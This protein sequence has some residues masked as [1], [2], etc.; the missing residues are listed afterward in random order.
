MADKSWIGNSAPW[1]GLAALLVVQFLL[2]YRHAAREIAW[3][4]PRNFDQ[5]IY[6]EHAYSTY[7]RMVHHG[8]GKG[9]LFGDGIGGGQTS[10]NGALLHLEA[11]LLFAAVGAG[12]ITGLC[13]G[14]IHFALLQIVLVFTLRKLSGRWSAAWLGLGLLLAARTTFQT[15]GGI[16]DFRM[17][18]DVFCTYA[19]FICFALLSN[20]YGTRTWSLGVGVV[21]GYLICFRFLTLAYFLPIFLLSFVGIAL[22]WGVKRDREY[23]RR[24]MW[25]RIINLLL[26]GGIAAVLCAPVLLHH[27]S[28]IDNY[29]FRLH[30]S[31]PQRY[32]RAQMFKNTTWSAVL[33]YYPRSLALHHAGLIF[34]AIAVLVIFATVLLRRRGGRVSELPDRPPFWPAMAYVLLCFVVP[35]A[36]LTWDVDKNAAVGDVLVGP[37]LWIVLLIT[38]GH[39]GDE[40]S[41]DT[42]LRPDN[43][44]KALAALALVAG[45]AVQVVSYLRPSELTVREPEVMAVL[46]LHDQIW[47]IS[48]QNN[49]RRPLI[50]NDSFADDLFPGAINV[51]AR[52]RHGT[53]LGA[54]EVLATDYVAKRTPQIIG[55]L[56]YCQFALTTRRSDGRVGSS[57]FD[58]SIAAARPQMEQYLREHYTRVTEIVAMDRHITL[59]VWSAGGN[60]LPGSPPGVPER[61]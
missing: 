12:R 58:A 22:T 55:A 28:A 46:R 53:L 38:L 25:P 45:L 13:V 36:A 39:A 20:L 5:A 57:P 59:W 61:E 34:V 29:Y 7:D 56:E 15:T 54:Q 50:A 31:G 49:W 41:E 8:I 52:E 16:M 48:R 21:V 30:A 14:F 47:A 60:P 18:F 3:A 9:L 37:L 33:L 10:G 26:A 4:Y 42:D 19:I 43:G 35:L 11:A 27:W 44:A 23:R 17:D 1:L 2:F 6:L 24:E 32:I 40:R 51:V